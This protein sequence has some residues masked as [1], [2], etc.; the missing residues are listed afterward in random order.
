M[1]VFLVNTIDSAG[2]YSLS[3]CGKTLS[4]TISKAARS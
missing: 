3:V 4:E 1:E 2:L